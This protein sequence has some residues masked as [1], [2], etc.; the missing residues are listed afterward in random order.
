MYYFFL[1]TLPLPVTP[2]ELNLTI[3]NQNK[4]VSLINDGEINILKLPGLSEV[5][6]EFMIP[7]TQYPFAYY[8]GGSFLTADTVLGYL[9]KLKAQRT[10]FQFI[11]SRMA[12][13]QLSFAT[14]IKV[15]LESYEIAESA[16]NGFDQTVR[17]TLK[18]YKPYS[19]KILETDKNGKTIVKKTRG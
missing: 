9:E 2:A 10:V 1:G 13:S 12:G 5:D 11:V 3:N 8:S 14:N 16:D 19:T 18:Q 6:F 17:V 15:S 7:H 4:T